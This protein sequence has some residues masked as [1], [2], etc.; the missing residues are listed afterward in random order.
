M[1]M[2]WSQSTYTVVTLRRARLV[3][4][5]VTVLE[6]VNHLGAEQTTCLGHPSVGRCGEYYGKLDSKQALSLIR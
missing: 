3:S 5:C 2:R 1:V 4:G 6:R